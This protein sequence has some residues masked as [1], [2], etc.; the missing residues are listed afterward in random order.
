MVQ[1]ATIPRTPVDTILQMDHKIVETATVRLTV[2]PTSLDD[3][4]K[5]NIS[6][7]ITQISTRVGTPSALIFLKTRDGNVLPRQESKIAFPVFFLSCV[8]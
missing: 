2:T 5:R 6:I 7:V 4:G 3:A 8:I 1:T